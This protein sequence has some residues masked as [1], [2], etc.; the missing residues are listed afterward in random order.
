MALGMTTVSKTLGRFQERKP[1]K[2][3]D[4][5]KTTHPE[6]IGVNWKPH[7][8]NKVPSGGDGCPNLEWASACVSWNVRLSERG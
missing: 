7:Y 2:L 4:E 1:K 6:F 5:A 3:R 8:H